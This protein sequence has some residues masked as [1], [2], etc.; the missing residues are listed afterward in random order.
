MLF[1]M[2]WNG[3]HGYLFRFTYF[4][5][6]FERI[7]C[8]IWLNC[9]VHSIVLAQIC[10]LRSNISNLNFFRIFLQLFPYF[11]FISVKLPWNVLQ[12]NG[13][14]VNWFINLLCVCLCVWS[15]A[16]VVQTPS[17]GSLF[18]IHIYLIAC[19]LFKLH[20][21]YPLIYIRTSIHTCIFNVQCI[22]SVWS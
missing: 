3:N 8:I 9:I 18:K 14:H 5:W 2:H 4:I 12:H 20:F 21:N 15:G 10:P 11:L 13:K 7:V 16:L 1:W 19:N 17:T 6:N 22:I